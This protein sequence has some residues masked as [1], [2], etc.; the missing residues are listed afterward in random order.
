MNKNRLFSQ[1]SAII[2]IQ[3]AATQTI[4]VQ[5]CIIKFTEFL[6]LSIFLIILTF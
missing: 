1:N 3:S 2:K 5:I 6:A 4:F